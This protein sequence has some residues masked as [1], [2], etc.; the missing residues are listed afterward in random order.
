MSKHQE[1]KMIHLL[2]GYARRTNKMIVARISLSLGTDS[3]PELQRLSSPERCGL[4]SISVICNASG[5]LQP[6]RLKNRMENFVTATDTARLTG[7][8]DCPLC[9]RA[10]RS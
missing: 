7:R 1:R 2:Y 9:C 6:K 10:R 4:I 3:T 5:R 8:R